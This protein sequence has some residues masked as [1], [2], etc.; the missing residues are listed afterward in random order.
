MTRAA[1][2]DYVRSN[3]TVRFCLCTSEMTTRY[4]T[5]LS[6][7]LQFIDRSEKDFLSCISRCGISIGSVWN[8]VKCETYSTKSFGKMFRQEK[9]NAIY[10]LK[11]KSINRRTC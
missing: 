3:N 6:E 8:I 11:K 10:E 9:K 1:L 2:Y 5:T 4:E 7:K